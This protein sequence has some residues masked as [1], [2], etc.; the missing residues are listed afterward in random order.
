MAVLNEYG[1]AATS[2]VG[3]LEASDLEAPMLNIQSLESDASALSPTV[4]RRL[5][6]YIGEA[7]FFS[8]LLQADLN[9]L[10]DGDAAIEVGSGIGLLALQ[11]GR[12]GHPI[13]AFEPESSGFGEMY[14]MR[15]LVRDN[16]VNDSCDI[17]WLDDRLMEYDSR[18]VDLT[19]K[20]AYAVNVLEHVVDIEEFLTTVLSNLRPGGQFRFI[21]PNY[22]YPYEPHF[23]MPTLFS[24]RATY[25]VMNRRI[26]AS[27]ISD[28]YGLWN[29]LSWPTTRSLRKL[30]VSMNL[31][32]CF[33]A[34]AT[35]A[36]LQRPLQDPTFMARKGRTAR[37]IFRV[38]ALTLP[39]VAN[40]LPRGGLPIIDCTIYV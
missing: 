34:S 15:N 10:K 3:A 25:S 40:N 28:P 19:P 31:R 12:L 4:Q 32:H 27:E 26:A 30:L 38:A 11:L 22:A 20:Y 24:K 9:S 14:A 37:S 17:R 29:E 18:I 39:R 33:H 23:E 1:N 6:T 2:K 16:W 8:Q 21:C 13:A 36:Y 5:W 35:Q 7:N